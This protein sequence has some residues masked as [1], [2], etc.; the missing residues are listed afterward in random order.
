MNLWD[1]LRGTR[2]APVANEADLLHRLA[3]LTARPA[4]RVTHDAKPLLARRT[5]REAR[6]VYRAW[7]QG[8]AA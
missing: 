8:E 7:S 1:W 5:T 4:Y 2:T 3:Q 6:R